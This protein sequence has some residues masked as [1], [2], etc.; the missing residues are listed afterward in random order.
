MSVADQVELTSAKCNTGIVC[1]DPM[2]DSSLNAVPF[3]SISIH[4]TWDTSDSISE[5]D[6]AMMSSW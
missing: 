4:W 6:R 1:H 5:F 2:V 3:G